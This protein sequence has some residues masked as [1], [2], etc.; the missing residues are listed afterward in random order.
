MTAVSSISS[1]TSSTSSAATTLNKT[2]PG[3]NTPATTQVGAQAGN[4]QMN[5]FLTLLTTQL[6]NQDPTQPTDPTQFVAQLAQ[7]STVEQLTQSNSTL[8][9]ISSSLSGM[10]LGQYSG[11]IN[12]SVTAPSSSITVPASGSV[13][14]NLS[15]TITNNA[16]SKPHVAVSNSSG[17]VVASLPVSGST[18]TVTFNGTDGNGN[19]LPAGSYTVAL[20][21]SAAGASSG[22]TVTAG[23]L[24]TT[25][26]V[27]G[28]AQASGGGW[29]LQLQDGESVSA[30]TVNSVTQPATTSD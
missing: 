22:T 18:G 9:S 10:T 13:A 19:N 23:T 29:N 3:A 26:V 17:V 20:V 7:F 5:Q 16:L 11:L 28:V 8:T 6:K 24:T 27:S 25:G 4:P 21:G 2:L 30:S 15:Y 1:A 14:T 12:R